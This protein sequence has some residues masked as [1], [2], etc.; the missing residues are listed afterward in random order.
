MAARRQLD[1]AQVAA[2][3]IEQHG[4]VDAAIIHARR[5][6]TLGPDHCCDGSR[7]DEG[8]SGPGEAC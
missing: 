7:H 6:E 3:E 1:G 2:V 8:S 5:S 4:R